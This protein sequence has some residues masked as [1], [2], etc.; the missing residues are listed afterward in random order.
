M[1][2]RTLGDEIVIIVDDRI[3][4]LPVNLECTISK[5]Y[6]DGFV[7][8]IA[9]DE[10]LSYIKCIGPPKKDSEGIVVFINNDFDNPVVICKSAGGGDSGDL[11]EYVKKKDIR[12][13]F[14]LCDNG[15]ITIGL[16]VGDG[17]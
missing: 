16:D 5:V 7:D 4:R 14:D 6:N 2:E 1:V 13:K 12:L 11:S 17:F 8:V 10:V 3:S 15:I 9:N